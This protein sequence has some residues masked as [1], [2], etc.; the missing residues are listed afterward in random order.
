MQNK[1]YFIKSKNERKKVGLSRVFNINLT[2]SHKN[3]CKMKL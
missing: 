1:D 2:E 3:S